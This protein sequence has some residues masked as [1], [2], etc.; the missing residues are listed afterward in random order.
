MQIVA[1]TK[2]QY[3]KRRASA[4]RL[5]MGLQK[6]TL[7]QLFALQTHHWLYR[8]LKL[9]FKHSPSYREWH[10]FKRKPRTVQIAARIRRKNNT[11]KPIAQPLLHDAI[12]QAR[13]IVFPASNHPVVTVLIPV[14]NKIEYTL[15]CLHSIQQYAPQTPF[16]VIALD[17][18]SNDG[19]AESLALI[20]GLTVVRNTENLGFLRNCNNGAKKARGKYLLFLN[21]DTRVLAG[22]LDEL[23]GT[24]ET[25]LNV[26]LVGSKL[27]YP[28]GMLQ[29]AGG[30]IW[31]D[32]SGWN[33]GRDTYP[34]NPAFN[35]VRDVD[36]CSGAS[37]MIPT[38]LFRALAGFDER[39]IPAYYEDTDLAFSVRK[40][41]YRVLFQPFSRVI[42]YE[43]VTS[44]T[45]LTTGIKAYQRHNQA[46]FLNKWR[47]ILANH[48]SPTQRVEFARERAVTKRALLIDATT[49]MPDQDSGSVDVI[50]CIKALQALGYKVTFIPDD[51]QHKDHYTEALQRMGVECQ[52]SH[53]IYSLAEQLE[54]SGSIYDL[55]IVRRVEIA[56]KYLKEI[57][58]HCIN[59]KIIFDTVDLHFLR[60]QRQATLVNSAKMQQQAMRTKLAEHE[61][62][63]QSDATIVISDV[64][65][66][67]V[68]DEWPDIRVA[69]IPYIRE[70]PGCKA[71]YASRED[72]VF[73]GGFRHLPNVDAVLHFVRDIWPLVR[74]LLPQARFLIVGSHVTPEI[75][76]LQEISGV[77]V[78]GHA[79]ELDPIFNR[80]R[81]TV[82]PLRFGA[83]IKGKVGTSLGYGVPCVASP[84]AAEGMRLTDRKNV[85]IASNSQ[86]FAKA[87]AEA[88]CD[89]PLWNHL[90][91]NGM[92]FMREH[93]SLEQ[94]ISH[95]RD[96]IDSLP[97]QQVRKYC[98]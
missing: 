85:L 53:Y 96:L 71:P 4:D 68:L 33:Y 40:S 70:I 1:H 91:D 43:G 36:Y 48:G 88:Y 76:A 8:N 23:L 77:V 18:C 75:Q 92:K 9:I 97:S 17:D 26:G 41:G 20:E 80:C 21:N 51:L 82:A 2:W 15:S 89:E 87:T 28:S 38:D 83:G 61:V 13:K 42:H 54:P 78:V 12:E 55:V 67:I 24:F 16:E 3:Q 72:I 25:H 46:K 60:E 57:R 81:L 30:I 6:P 56:A 94:G 74:D 31:N 66:K 52:Y 90:S 73:I 47:D 98:S 59:A 49:P 86:S 64:E 37:L 39:Y 93:H 84:I 34:D 63:K 50:S 29:E 79:A 11:A 65:R 45:D 69:T 44:G 19:T 10:Q 14:Y 5:E 58:R 22:W 95:M 7:G 35:Y 62:M 27:L 32:A